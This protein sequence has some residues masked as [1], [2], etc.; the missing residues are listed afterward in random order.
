MSTP[1]KALLTICLHLSTIL[2]VSANDSYSNYIIE[3]RQDALDRVCNYDTLERIY[4]QRNRIYEHGKGGR[5]T[6]IMS[7]SAEHAVVDDSEMYCH[8]HYQWYANHCRPDAKCHYKFR[9]EYI[10]KFPMNP[11][12]ENYDECVKYMQN[13]KGATIQNDTRLNINKDTASGATSNRM[14]NGK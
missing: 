3:S 2:L 11:F 8:N 5:G 14:F 4:K 12:D 9:H 10:C 6:G 7:M 1:N 13:K